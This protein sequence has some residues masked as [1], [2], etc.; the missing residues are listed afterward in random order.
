MSEQDFYLYIDGKPVKVSEEVYREYYRAEEKERYFMTRLKQERI[1]I[2]QETQTVTIIPSRED[3][4][5]R[6]IEA[7]EQFATSDKSVAET[8]VKAIQLEKLNEALH[9]L[10]DE[11]MTL[12]RELFYLNRTVRE[13]SEQYQIARSTLQSRKEAVL[14]KLWNLL[15]RFF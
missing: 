6:L 5:E 1:V 15:E 7:N 10:S 3:S 14:R 9:T 11:E 2:D 13:V 12:I 8:V 4:Y